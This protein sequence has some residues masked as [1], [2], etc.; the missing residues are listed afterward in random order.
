MLELS[1]DNVLDYLRETG[2]IGK[3]GGGHDMLDDE[4]VQAAYLGGD[5]GTGMKPEL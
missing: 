5:V 3:E 2:R 4:A 1:A